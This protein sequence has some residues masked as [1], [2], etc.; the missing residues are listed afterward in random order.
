MTCFEQAEYKMPGHHE[1]DF[2][3]SFQLASE[4]LRVQPQVAGFGSA[5]LAI[6]P[7]VAVSCPKF[8]GMFGRVSTGQNFPFQGYVK[9]YLMMKLTKI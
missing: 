4:F 2:F 3:R 6:W 7:S 1:F 5:A 8:V 9:K